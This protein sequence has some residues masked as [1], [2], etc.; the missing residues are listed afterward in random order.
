[1]TWRTKK[2]LSARKAAP[3]LHTAEVSNLNGVNYQLKIKRKKNEPFHLFI[4]LLILEEKR[5]KVATIN[6]PEGEWKKMVE[7]LNG[8][9]QGIKL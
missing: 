3:R 4:R 8:V 6:R 9:Q 5:M 1:M 2:E 7:P